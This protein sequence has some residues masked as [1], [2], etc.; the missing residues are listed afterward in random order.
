MRQVKPRTF[1]VGLVIALLA[2]VGLGTFRTEIG[3]AHV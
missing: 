2:G 1:V 3:R